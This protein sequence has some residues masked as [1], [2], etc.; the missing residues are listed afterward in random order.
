M[1]CLICKTAMGIR[2][3]KFGPFYYC[4]NGNHGTISVAKY[5]SIV[6]RLPEPERLPMSGECP[7]IAEIERQTMALGGG[8]MT[9][10]ERFYVDSEAY[11]DDPDD[12]WQNR[13]NYRR[14]AA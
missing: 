3:G 8:V 7:L 13:D 4:P 5:E 6:S 14:C 10:A 9:D 1:I 12:F 11:Y 2:E